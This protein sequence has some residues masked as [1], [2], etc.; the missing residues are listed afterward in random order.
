MHIDL[1]HT[2][3]NIIPKDDI[4]FLKTILIQ[5]NNLDLDKAQ[6]IFIL[7]ILCKKFDVYLFQNKFNIKAKLWI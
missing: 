4:G 2:F 7:K 6:M 1:H 3:V 5:Y